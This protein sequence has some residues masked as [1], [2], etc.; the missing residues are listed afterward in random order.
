MADRHVAL[1]AI[2]DGTGGEVIAD[3][4]HPA[5][6]ME[7]FTI[8]ADDAGCF[9]SAVLERMQA[10]RRQRCGVGMVEDAEH[11]TFFVEPVFF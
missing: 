2:D 10:Q 1:Q 9:L 6:R 7:V 5:L 8:K 4:A 3:E 11:T